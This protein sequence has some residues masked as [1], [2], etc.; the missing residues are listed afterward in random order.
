M[1]LA[2]FFLTLYYFV[3]CFIDFLKKIKVVGKSLNWFEAY[4]DTWLRTLKVFLV[5]F[6]GDQNERGKNRI[7]PIS[8]YTKWMYRTAITSQGDLF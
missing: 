5:S 4:Q 2:G 8:H 7:L 3:W 6:K 1:V